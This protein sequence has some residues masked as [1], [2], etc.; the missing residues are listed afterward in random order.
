M[1]TGEQLKQLSPV[2]IGSNPTVNEDVTKGYIVGSVVWSISGTAYYYCTDASAGGAVWVLAGG[3]VNSTIFSSALAIVQVPAATTQYYPF[4]GSNATA[5]TVES[6]RQSLSPATMVLGGFYFRTNS[7]QPATG[8]LV[9]NVRVNGANSGITITIAAGA[10]AGNFSDLSN[11]VA[12][13]PGD[14]L[15]IQVINNALT[16]GAQMSGWGITGVL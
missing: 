5:I 10:A 11:T 8:T 3:G 16:A 14:L 9:I 7:A 12:V 2:I 1:I 6:Q 13:V 4:F 15:T